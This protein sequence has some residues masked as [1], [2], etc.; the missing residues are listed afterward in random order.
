MNG[1]VSW[2]DRVNAYLSY[3]RS[4]GYSPLPESLYLPQFARFAEQQHA[5]RLTVQLAMALVH[6]SL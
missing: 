6:K 4:V 2:T 5:P 3:R 1:T